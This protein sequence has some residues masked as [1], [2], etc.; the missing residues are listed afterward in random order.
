[1]NS[2]LAQ[3]QALATVHPSVI[4]YDNEPAFFSSA[5]RASVLHATIICLL[6]IT[7]HS[8][9]PAWPGPTEVDGEKD[10]VIYE[11]SNMHGAS[12]Q[13]APPDGT[14]QSSPPMHAPPAQPTQTT[15]ELP[16]THVPAKKIPAAAAQA[17]GAYQRYRIQ[18]KNAWYKESGSDATST[19]EQRL[20]ATTARAYATGAA[21]IEGFAQHRMNEQQAGAQNMPLSRSQENVLRMARDLYFRKTLQAARTAAVRFKRTLFNEVPIHKRITATILIGKR[22]TIISIT[23]SSSCGSTII[24]AMFTE[25]LNSIQFPPLPPQLPDPYTL[26]TYFDVDLD[27]GFGPLA[28]RVYEPT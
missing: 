4:T 12:T 8:E 14:A 26:N 24:D 27:Q 22:G 28:I 15:S 2:S 5:L 25:Y 3:T 17:A 18:G 10:M 7:W 13:K 16:A 6:F 1:M 23:L 11:P 20:S 9:Y 19:A 21:L